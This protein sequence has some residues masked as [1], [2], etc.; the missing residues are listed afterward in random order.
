M[1][2]F[3]NAEHPAWEGFDFDQAVADG[4]WA[5]KDGIFDSQIVFADGVFPTPSTKF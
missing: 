5:R 3:V 4:I 2:S 1:R